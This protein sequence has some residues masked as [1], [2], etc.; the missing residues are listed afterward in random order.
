MNALMNATTA[1]ATVTVCHYALVHFLPYAETGEFC[2]VGVVMFSPSA[3]FF[4][5]KLLK[6]PL[7]R[8]TNFFK[9][10]DGDA[11]AASLDATADEL[12]R[13]RAMLMPL[14][15]DRRSRVFDRATATQLW[16]ETVK[17]R[18]SAIRFSESRLVMANGPDHKLN[19]LY[20]YYVA[21]T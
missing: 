5:F 6:P 1:D 4:D 21:G 11:V 20:A 9:Q 13:V 3:R 12:Q 17:P 7:S 14:G 16:L 19:E 2:N 8:I 15:L 18:A 10:L